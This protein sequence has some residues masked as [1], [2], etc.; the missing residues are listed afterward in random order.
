MAS[1]FNNSMVGSIGTSTTDLYTV[2]GGASTTVIGLSL[3]NILPSTMVYATVTLTKGASSVSIIKNGPIPPGS[4]LVLFGGD[5]KLVM[6]A[7]DKISILSSNATSIDAV[8]SYL[9]IT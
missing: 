9:Q 4:S 8:L 6:A 5:Q 1:T 2:P 3:A 7:G